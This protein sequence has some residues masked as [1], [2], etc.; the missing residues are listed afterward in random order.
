MT[1]Y[2]VY[3][4]SRQ[5]KLYLGAGLVLFL[6][7]GG[8]L[9][10]GSLLTVA[11]MPLL[12]CSMSRKLGTMLAAENRKKLRSRFRD[13]LYCISASF[14]SGRH[15]REAIGEA[16]QELNS[17]YGEKDMIVRELDHMLRR[18]Q[19][20]GEPDVAVLHDFAERSGLEDVHDFVRIYQACR[21]TGGDIVFAMNKTARV[22]GEKITIEQEIRT[23]V[24]QKKAEGRIITVMP[25]LI[26]LFLKGISP[27]YLEVMY[28]TVGGR[29]MMTMAV[30]GIIGAY[31]WIERITDID[32]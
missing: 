3:V 23:I 24:Q 25:I 32:V 21:E 8:Y 28:T 14:A 20:N 30:A 17:M 22:I 18:M 19:V 31:L 13:L 10:Y 6:A 27:E 9:F 7:A 15:M 11:L 1:D 16:R 12:F 5:Q 26:I 2:R 4:L 29:L